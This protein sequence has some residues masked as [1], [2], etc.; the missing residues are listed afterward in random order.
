MTHPL[1]QQ[2][3]VAAL[4]SIAVDVAGLRNY[5][6]F[7][8]IEL[9]TTITSRLASISGCCS[10]MRLDEFRPSGPDYKRYCPVSPVGSARM[11]PR[12]TVL[13]LVTDLKNLIRFLPGSCAVEVIELACD[14]ASVAGYLAAVPTTRFSFQAPLSCLRD[15]S[16]DPEV[17]L[18]RNVIL[19]E[20]R[21]SIGAIRTSQ[22]N[23]DG[24]PSAHAAKPTRPGKRKNANF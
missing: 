21:Q 14:L 12:P 23:T 3:A 8:C 1:K 11:I 4:E 22:K 6:P 5:V 10:G 17:L 16:R 15:W 20:D 18:H 2:Q 24:H 7:A 13:W 19:S 9:L